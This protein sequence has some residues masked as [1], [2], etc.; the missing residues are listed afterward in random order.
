MLSVAITTVEAEEG[1][2]YVHTCTGAGIGTATYSPAPSSAAVPISGPV[3][4]TWVD[5][6]ITI[7]GALVNLGD[8]SAGEINAEGFD[9]CGTAL[10]PNPFAGR[11]N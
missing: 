10:D 9:L 5:G 8:I 4:V 11:I 3:L 6:V 2:S 1:E 7:K